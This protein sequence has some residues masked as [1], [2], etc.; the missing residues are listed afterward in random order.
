METMI[1]EN[2]EF[3]P[4]DP[5]SPPAS[6]PW[7]SRWSSVNAPDVMVTNKGIQFPE[8]PVWAT[9]GTG[10][11]SRLEEMLKEIAT[12]RA[13]NPVFTDSMRTGGGDE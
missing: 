10:P 13:G 4:F 5:A 1:H 9:L 3:A 2:M 6:G 7:A 11:I 12:G 8:V